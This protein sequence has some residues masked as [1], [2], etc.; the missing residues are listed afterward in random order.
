MR[1]HLW[2]LSLTLIAA[3]SEPPD[4]QQASKSSPGESASQPE[5]KAQPSGSALYK[6][7]LKPGEKTGGG[8]PQKRGTPNLPSQPTDL[9][10][11]GRARCDD[12]TR[13]QLVLFTGS[14]R[15]VTPATKLGQ[16]P[17]TIVRTDGR[18]DGERALP[19]SALLGEGSAL[20]VWPCASA[21]VK[22]DAAQIREPQSQWLLIPTKRGFLKIRDV[23]HADKDQIRNIAAI[24]VEGP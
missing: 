17:D 7:R 10:D 16:L 22:L 14:E 19:L 15:T 12:L 9:K 2:L 20:T 13:R 6:K 18:H 24:V 21:P 23:A 4:E 8:K 1:N 3:C 11:D 5:D